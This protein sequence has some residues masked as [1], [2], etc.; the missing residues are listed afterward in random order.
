MTSSAILS[1]MSLEDT[2]ASPHVIILTTND[3]DRYHLLGSYYVLFT[4]TV[5]S[6]IL[7]WDIFIPP[8]TDRKTETQGPEKRSQ[9]PKVTKWIGSSNK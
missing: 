7:A 2:I 6:L 5:L 4:Y 3:D 9:S 1:E 8:F